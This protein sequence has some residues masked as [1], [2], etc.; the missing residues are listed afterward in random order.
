MKQIMII[1][2][3]MGLTMTLSAQ[4][5]HGTGRTRVVVVSPAIGFGYSPFYYSPY[6]YSAFGYPYGYNNTYRGTSKL[7]MKIED[8]KTDYSDKIKSARHDNSLNRDERKKIIQQLKADRD[9]AVRD[10]K[11][12]YY[13][14][15]KSPGDTSDKG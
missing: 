11:T 9:N 3:V 1:V 15:Q 6:G 2:V 8:I 7:S 13:K 12:N 4:R 14:P 10:L 5:G